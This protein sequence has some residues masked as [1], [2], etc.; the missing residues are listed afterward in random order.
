M[1]SGNRLTE[2]SNA[3]SPFGKE[4]RCKQAFRK[5]QISGRMG[6][7]RPY[8]PFGQSANGNFPSIY[9]RRQSRCFP[10]SL[11]SDR[12]QEIRRQST[13][14]YL[15]WHEI[16]GGIQRPPSRMGRIQV[17]ILVG[18]LI[19]FQIELADHDQQMIEYVGLNTFIFFPHLITRK[20]IDLNRDSISCRFF[21]ADN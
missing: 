5:L 13:F 3:L 8:H 6:V 17:T 14:P 21:L 1:K 12:R 16:P 2:I 18:I 4:K 7:A 10:C 11:S 9:R 19:Q 15:L 20:E